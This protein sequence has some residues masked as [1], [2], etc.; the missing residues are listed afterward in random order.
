MPQERNIFKSLTVEEN[1]TAVARPGPWTWSASRAV[2]APGE[3]RCNL[4]NQLSGGEQQML[5]IGRALVLNPKL[6]LLD[7]PHEGLAPIIVEELLAALRRIIRE[8]GMSAIVVEQHAQKI[9]GVTD[10]AIILDRGRIVH[11]RSS[12]ALIDDPAPWTSIWASPPEAPRTRRPSEHHQKENAMQRTKPPF[13]ADMVG[14]LLR[15]APLKEAREKR[16]A[17]RDRRR[18]RCKAVEDAEIRELIA[19]QEEIGLQAVTDGEFRRAFWH[20]DF[21]EHLDGVDAIEADRG[22][23]FKGGIDITKAHARHGQ[24]RLLRTTRCSST[25]GS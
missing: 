23:K 6:L 3:R 8:E 2:S 25:S 5:A 20:F 10:E 7:E 16:R 12:R 11:A 21:L 14:S 1:L 9:L 4:G 13:R 22:M 15:T 18:R 24:G 19:R 17:R